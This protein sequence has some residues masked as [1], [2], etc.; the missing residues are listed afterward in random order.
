MDGTIA[1]KDNSVPPYIEAMDDRPGSEWSEDECAR[2][3]AWWCDRCRLKL[4]W[5]SAARYLGMGATAQDV[6]DAVS[7]F[8]I[9]FDRIR[10]SY[11]PGAGPI[12]STYLVHVCFRNY[13]LAQGKKIRT[14]RRREISLDRQIDE[15]APFEL[16]LEEM[17]ADGDPHR[18][19]QRRAFLDDLSRL[20]NGP[21]LSE[22]HREVF[23]L[24][25]FEELSYEEIAARMK[26][27]VGSVKGWLSRATHTLREGL[28][29][30]GWTR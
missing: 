17:G 23:V 13:C 8:Y 14:R 28:T 21:M 4:V 27:P 5:Y 30:R 11:R 25:H 20:L 19:A 10:R 16:E 7:Q 24:R 6:E 29:E 18:Q 26:A 22:K 9:E 3:M 15:E 1:N 12:F 2:M